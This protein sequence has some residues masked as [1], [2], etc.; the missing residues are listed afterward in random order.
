[1]RKVTVP[2]VIG[3]GIGFAV[4]WLVA[5]AS[6]EVKHERIIIVKERPDGSPGLELQPDDVELREDMV[7]TWWVVNLTDQKVKVSIVNWREGNTPR[8]AAVRPS[9][10]DFDAE[11]PQVELSRKVPKKKVR[12]IRAKARRPQGIVASEKLRYD[13]YLNDQ[14]ALDP[15]V[16][17]VL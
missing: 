4:G 8:P 1:M 16:K 10:D 17:L 12:K 2:A 11:D 14:P 9:P 15:I 7:L 13:I 5:R 6:A 3:G